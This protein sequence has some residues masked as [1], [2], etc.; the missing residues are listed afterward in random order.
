MQNG[1]YISRSKLI[2]RFNEDNCRVQCVS[3]NVFKSGEVIT[4]RERLVAEIGEDKV[5][6]MERTR[7]DV[8]KVDASWYEAKIEYYKQLVKT[9]L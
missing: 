1:H 8:F 9:L 3:C 2:H 4:Y 5:L 7:N 6:E